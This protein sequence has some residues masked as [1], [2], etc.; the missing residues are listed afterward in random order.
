VTAAEPRRFVLLRRLGIHPTVQSLVREELDAAI[1]AAE[2]RRPPGGVAALDAGCGRV[3]ALRPFRPRIGR[4]VGADLHR[5]P[6]GALPYLDDFVEADLCSGDPSVF[7]PASFDVILSSFT[8]EHFTDPDAAF[9]AF[10]HWLRPG[11]ALVATT[12]N[13]RHPLVA[14]YLGAPA[15]VRDRLQP[16][17]KASPGDA[18]PIVGVCNDPKSVQAALVGAGFASV[19]VATVSHL[20]RAWGRTMPTFLAGLAGDLLAHASPARRSTI[21]AVARAAAADQDGRSR[22]SQATSS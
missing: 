15:G 8:I 20:A 18:H 11:G 9:R 5:P 7:P 21:V 22:A 6:A 10:R 2:A 13:R 14:A 17:V 19:R 12:V 1:V 3:S 16:V 4:L